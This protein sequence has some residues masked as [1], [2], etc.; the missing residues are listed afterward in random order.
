AGL[1]PT[2]EQ[3]GWKEGTD[4][5]LGLATLSIIT[6]VITGLVMINYY[7]RKYGGVDEDDWERQQRQLIRGGYNLIALTQKFNT[8]PKA[9]FINVIAFATSIAIGWGILQSLIFAESFLLSGYTDMRFFAYVPLFPL[10]M[11]GGL[12]VQL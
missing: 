7:K 1:A 5:A 6:A 4:I 12:I 9:V 2:F 10:A 3:L 11:I 8:N